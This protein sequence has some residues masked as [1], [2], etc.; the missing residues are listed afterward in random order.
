MF[1]GNLNNQ[2]LEINSLDENIKTGIEWLKSADLKNMKAGRYEISPDMYV[3]IDEYKSGDKEYYEAHRRYAD[4]QCMILGEEL[5]GVTNLNNCKKAIEYNPE[6][7]IEFLDSNDKTYYK[8]T[9]SDFLVL[10]PNDAHKPCLKVDQPIKIKKAVV[11]V[12]I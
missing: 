8:L 6:K 12:R 2:N 5:I 9:P 10:M 4:I 3:N 1:L 11:K 7:D